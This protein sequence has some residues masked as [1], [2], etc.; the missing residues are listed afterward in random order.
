M[1][2]NTWFLVRELAWTDFKLRYNSLVL[3]Y[4]WS[5]LHPLLVFGVLYLVFSVFL[6]IEGIPNY[7]LYLLLGVILWSYFAES[8]TNGMQSMQV[9]AGLISKV[10]VPK[11]IILAASGITSLLTLLLNLAVFAVFWA[12]SS[13]RPAASAWLFPLFLLE[14]VVLS[15]A[16]SLWLSSFY[17]KF[18][19]LSHLWGVALQIGFW[20]TPIVYPVQAIP[21]RFRW[22]FQWNPLARIIQDARSALLGPETL[23][24][25]HHLV[26]LAMVLVLLALGAAVF[27]RRSARFAQEI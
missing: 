20:L 1:R 17:L 8:T 2:T 13:A 18:R 11:G 16:L 26:S 22:L 10:Y 4:L 3:G 9:K 19:D 27:A 12:A 23:P 6:K 21:G 5:L 25:G 14:L 24:F 7:R 15:F